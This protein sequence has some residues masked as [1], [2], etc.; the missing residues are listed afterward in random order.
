VGGKLG[1]GQV[2]LR[3][4]RRGDHRLSKSGGGLLEHPCLWNSS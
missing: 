3:F 1:T 2:G 4:R